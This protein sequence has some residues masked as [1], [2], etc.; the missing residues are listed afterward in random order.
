MKTLVGTLEARFGKDAPSG[1]AERVCALLIER[2]MVTETN[3][4]L[5]FNLPDDASYCAF[6]KS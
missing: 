5:A 6:H 3:G 2:G 1:E 4:K